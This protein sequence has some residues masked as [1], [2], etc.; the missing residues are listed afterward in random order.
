MRSGEAEEG[1]ELS[2]W[3]VR[4]GEADEG[5]ELRFWVVVSVEAD[6]DDVG[7]S[8]RVTSG[9]EEVG[10]VKQ[11]EMQNINKSMNQII[12]LNEDGNSCFVKQHL[13]LL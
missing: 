3:V 6:G 11:K 13:N 1:T 2:L 9:F 7:N 12:Q 10:A 4:S 5:T 8:R